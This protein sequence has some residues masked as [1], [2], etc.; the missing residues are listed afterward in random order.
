M[1]TWQ[2]ERTLSK[3]LTLHYR[4]KML[5]VTPTPETAGLVRRR[6]RVFEWD[7]GHLEVVCDGRPPTLHALRQESVRRPRR[8]RREQAAECR[9][10]RRDDERLQSA[11][12]SLR[13]K[14]WIRQ[15]SSARERLREDDV[16]GTHR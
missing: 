5:M 4:K 12:V 8:S 2:E 7:D 10:K 16:L 13:E 9:Q 6:V 3:S 15:K 11:K 14:K 1:F